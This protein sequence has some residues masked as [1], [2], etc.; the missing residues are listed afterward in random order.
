MV[1]EVCLVMGEKI[2]SRG[3]PPS[4][5]WRKVTPECLCSFKDFILQAIYGPMLDGLEP[6]YRPYAQQEAFSRSV[7]E[8]SANMGC[9]VPST[10]EEGDVATAGLNVTIAYPSLGGSPVATVLKIE[11]I[12]GSSMSLL[13][14]H[15]R[16][17]Y[18]DCN[19][20]HSCS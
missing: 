19:V 15:R 7:K 6:E 20:Q 13:D 10:Y 18:M 2:R 17:L 12:G 9:A 5:T 11:V 16:S 3:Y 14:P 1:D 4:V 8:R